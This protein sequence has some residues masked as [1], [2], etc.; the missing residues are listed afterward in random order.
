M[1]VGAAKS[2]AGFVVK[3]RLGNPLPE[4]RDG[5]ITR[6]LIS[7]PERL[8]SYIAFLL[9]DPDG[10]P[11]D[12]TALSVLTNPEVLSS[13]GNA[14]NS[15][16]PTFPLMEKMV[17]AVDRDPESIDRIAAVIR[18]LE[19]TEDGRNLLPKDLDRVWKPV[20]EACRMIR[21]KRS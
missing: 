2:T 7:S 15:S 9:A 19:K 14:G 3:A 16:V 5:E 17:Q 12:L 8:L 4:D 10:D 6:E 21:D 18:E 11:G 20:V 1:K 13:A